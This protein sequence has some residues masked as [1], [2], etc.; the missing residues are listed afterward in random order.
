MA[1]FPNE[2]PLSTHEA[3]SI[4]EDNAFSGFED[5]LNNTQAGASQT[6]LDYDYTVAGPNATILLAKPRRTGSLWA[7]N[8][9]AGHPN[10]GEWVENATFDPRTGDI[11]Y[12]AAQQASQATTGPAGVCMSCGH[13]QTGPGKFC[14]MCGDPLT[15][16]TAVHAP[17]G[18]LGALLPPP[19]APGPPPAPYAAPLQPGQ[20]P[21]AGAGHIAPPAHI[22]P[23]RMEGKPKK[24]VEVP[25]GM[26][27]V[28]KSTG[29]SDALDALLA[30]AEADPPAEEQ[31]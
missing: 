31:K 27:R 7:C 9:T 30:Q 2:R 21:S 29:F 15:Q 22:N 19:A 12:N 18:S 11:D 1:Q 28:A 6:K 25:E 24:E 5:E 23:N 16:G 26:T 3:I 17:V 20:T 10:Q 4:A 8:M 13:V 14:A